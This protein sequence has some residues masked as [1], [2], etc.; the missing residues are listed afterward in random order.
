MQQLDFNFGSIFI[1][2]IVRDAGQR[3]VF[4][5]L[6]VLAIVPVCC[7]WSLQ[8][9]PEKILNSEISK[10][11]ALRVPEILHNAFSNA[12]SVVIDPRS[13]RSLYDSIYASA[14][15]SDKTSPIKVADIISQ[16]IDHHFDFLESPTKIKVFANSI[17][18][19]LQSEGLLDPTE[20]VSFGLAL[21]NSLGEAVGNSLMEGDIE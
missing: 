2:L 15:S 18:K 21:A 8:L 5:S 10:T 4:F 20:A 11:N 14:R 19:H 3:A 12:L 16:I 17:A 7:A 9:N 6:A 13:K 1:S